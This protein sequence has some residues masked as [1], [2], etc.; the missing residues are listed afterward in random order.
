MFH[1]PVRGNDDGGVHTT[2]AD[3][4]ALW[5]SLFAGRIVSPEIV[6]EVVGGRRG[7]ARASVGTYVVLAVANR[8]VD[9]CSKLAF[10]KLEKEANRYTASDFLRALIEAVPYKIHTVLTDNGMQF[11]HAPRNRSGPTAR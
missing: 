7:D 3:V 1:L 10:A 2:A 5:E 11:C 4:H 8:L 6:D 9:P